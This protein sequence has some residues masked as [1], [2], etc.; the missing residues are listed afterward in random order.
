M[1]RHAD[2]ALIEIAGQ[3]RSTAA[4]LVRASQA[5]ASDD[6]G[7]ADASTEEMLAEPSDDP[8]ERREDTRT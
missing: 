7:L 3:V 1:A 6:D 4:D 8:R 5:G 2:L